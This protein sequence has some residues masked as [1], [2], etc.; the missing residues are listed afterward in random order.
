MLY[1]QVCHNISY[2]KLYF[3]LRKPNKTFKN[4]VDHIYWNMPFANS[5]NVY[6]LITYR[7]I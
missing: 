6:L 1:S 4:N 7:P 5:Y 3:I 2:H